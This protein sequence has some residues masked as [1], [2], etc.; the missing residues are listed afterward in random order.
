ML[1]SYSMGAASKIAAPFF[2]V[3]LKHGWRRALP[4]RDGEVEQDDQ[5]RE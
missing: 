5:Q 4:G 3:K 1:G 2:V